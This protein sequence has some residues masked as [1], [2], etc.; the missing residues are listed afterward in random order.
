[1]Q[2]NIEFPDE[3]IMKIASDLSLRDRANFFAVNR[4]LYSFCAEYH[5]FWLE[6]LKEKRNF[7][8][9]ISFIYLVAGFF[10]DKINELLLPVNDKLNT[11]LEIAKIIESSIIEY[12]RNEYNQFSVGESHNLNLTPSIMLAAILSYLIVNAVIAIDD[13]AKCKTVECEIAK[14]ASTWNKYLLSFS[15]MLLVFVVGPKLIDPMVEKLVKSVLI[16]ISP[17]I[18]SSKRNLTSFDRPIQASETNSL[19]CE[20]SSPLAKK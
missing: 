1:M 17:A 16:A 2:R 10:R 4:K 14:A 20:F 13:S 12:R 9:R 3:I 19:I 5:S 6:Q 15:V 18:R 7:P 8:E 11:K